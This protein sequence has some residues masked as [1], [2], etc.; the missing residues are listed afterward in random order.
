MLWLYSNTVCRVLHSDQIMCWTL[1]YL[2]CCIYHSDWWTGITHIRLPRKHSIHI[3][4]RY[5]YSVG[6]HLHRMV[7]LKHICKMS[8]CSWNSYSFHSQPLP[9]N[10]KSYYNLPWYLCKKYK[11]LFQSYCMFHFLYQN[12]KSHSCLLH[13]YCSS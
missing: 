5:H 10:N 11:K 1:M 13:Y 3:L 9:Y 6:I 7:Q 2:L 8:V 12:G 4:L